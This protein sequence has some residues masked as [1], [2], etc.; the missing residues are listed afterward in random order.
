MSDCIRQGWGNELLW[1]ASLDTQAMLCSLPACF[2][3]WWGQLKW[4]IPFW[5]LSVEWPPYF[6]GK[7]SGGCLLIVLLYPVPK[8]SFLYQSVIWMPF[9]GVPLF[10]HGL[11]ALVL[12]IGAISNPYKKFNFLPFCLSQLWFTPSFSEQSRAE[13]FLFIPNARQNFTE[14]LSLW[15][16]CP[17]QALF[18]L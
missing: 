2:K 9:C 7:L 12:R 8:S 11:T 16:A 3:A 18:C 17:I 5:I 6:L 10:S 1:L 13:Y 4:M 14:S 15:N